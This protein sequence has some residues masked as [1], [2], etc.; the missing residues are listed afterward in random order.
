VT[1]DK[2]LDRGQ[3]NHMEG[4]EGSQKAGP[5][6]TA[7]S[8]RRCG[9]NQATR[10]PQPNQSQTC[11]RMNPKLVHARVSTSCSLHDAAAS[12]QNKQNGRI[13]RREPAGGERASER[14]GFGTT[15]VVAA[16]QQRERG[17]TDPFVRAARAKGGLLTEQRRDRARPLATG[18]ICC[19][20]Y[21]HQWSGAQE[22]D[23]RR[24]RRRRGWSCG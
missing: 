3:W 11:R 21:H 5:N 19:T 22:E 18:W 2:S 7:A 16:I 4:G 24:R 8:A 15:E 9:A 10:H 1:A 14:I 6:E 12:N 17:G 23:W 20:P 13:N